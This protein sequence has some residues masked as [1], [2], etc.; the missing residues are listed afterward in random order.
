MKERGNKAL[1]VLDRW[2]GIPIVFLLGGFRK[3]R[4]LPG[5]VHSVGLLMIGAI[6]DSLLASSLI[7]DFRANS[8]HRAGGH[9][10]KS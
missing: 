2:L 4:N 7:D 5:M 6:G 8:D 10:R 9:S 1:R 3:R